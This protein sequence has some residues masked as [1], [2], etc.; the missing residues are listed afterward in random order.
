MFRYAVRI[1]NFEVYRH[2]F[3]GQFRSFSF[4]LAGPQMPGRV[5]DPIRLLL[6]N[7]VCIAHCA[8]FTIFV[9]H[10][11]SSQHKHSLW[12]PNG[13]WHPQQTP[14]LV[15]AFGLLARCAHLLIICNSYGSKAVYH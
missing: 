1:V 15:D 3:S 14:R 6:K 12:T 2:I 5:D 9:L 11:R 10:T 7:N 13:A 4:D 8:M